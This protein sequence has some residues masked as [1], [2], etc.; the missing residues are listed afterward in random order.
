MGT[1]LTMRVKLIAYNGK[2]SEFEQELATPGCDPRATVAIRR[3]GP[4]ASLVARLRAAR[5]GPGITAFTLKLPKTLTRGKRRPVV[6]AGGRACARSA[7]GA[8]PRC[9]S[10]AR[11]ARPG[12]CGAACEPAPGSGAER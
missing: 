11:S 12:S 5:D 7:A 9:R 3:R 8:A 10:P 4:T 6:I 2:Q 1:D